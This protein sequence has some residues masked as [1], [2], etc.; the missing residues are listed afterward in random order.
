MSPSE[1][2]V[3]EN[4]DIPK[5]PDDELGK[6]WKVVED[7]VRSMAETTGV[8]VPRG[9][10]AVKN[11]TD[12]LAA[13]AQ[14][15]VDGSGRFQ[16]VQQTFDKTLTC[17]RTLGDIVIGPISQVFGGPA[18][19][20]FNALTFVILAYQG[21]KG[22]FE[23]LAQ[24]LQGFIESLGRL[25]DIKKL[26]PTPKL[27]LIACQQLMLFVNVCDLT[28]KLRQ[29]V[30]FKARAFF[31]ST[32][33]NNDEVKN[34]I[35]E[36]K[37]LNKKEFRQIQMDILERL[38]RVDRNVNGFMFDWKTG[39][40][41]KKWKSTVIDELGWPNGSVLQSTEGKIPI[42]FWKERLLKH[43][44]RSSHDDGRWLWN[45]ERFHNWA[46]GESHHMPVL[47]LEGDE[48]T[49]KTHLASKIIEHLNQLGKGSY[50]AYYFVEDS[51]KTE[52]N[53][54][55]DTEPV[56]IRSLLWQFA[57]SCRPFLKSTA[58]VCETKRLMVRYDDMW[59]LLISNVASGKTEARFFIVIDGL[60][61]AH[62]KFAKSLLDAVES[63]V[64]ACQ[65]IRILIT[66]VPAFFSDL[67]ETHEL[68]IEVIRL[69]DENRSDI[70]NFID[71]R[72]NRMPELTNRS[73]VRAARMRRRISNKLVGSARGD[74]RNMAH[75]LDKIKKKPLDQDWVENCL[76]GA[77]STAASKISGMVQSID[78]QSPH[79]IFDINEMIL[80]VIDGRTW[81][82]LRQMAAAL[83][84]AHAAESK[85]QQDNERN[86]TARKLK[87][88]I[89]GGTYSLFERDEDKEIKFKGGLS[90]EEA[91]QGIPHKRSNPGVA[92]GGITTDSMAIQLAEVNLV[93]HYLQTVCPKSLY[94][95]FG[96]TEFFEQK[97]SSEASYTCQ[98]PANAEL[99]LSLRCL[100]CLV[101]ER[102]PETRALYSYAA[103]NLHEHLCSAI[104][105]PG[106]THDERSSPDDE[107]GATDKSDSS[108]DEMHSPYRSQRD[109]FLQ[110]QVAGY[111]ARLFLE[112]YA[113]DSLFGFCYPV[114]DDRRSVLELKELP[115][116]W[117]AWI[118]DDKALNLLKTS[119]FRDTDVLR[120]T[121]ESGLVKSLTAPN[122]VIEKQPFELLK[123]AVKRA[124][125]HLL[126]PGA[127]TYEIET[128]FAF[129][130][131]AEAR[132]N[133]EDKVIDEDNI[134]TPTVE[135]VKAVEVWALR[136]SASDPTSVWTAHVAAVLLNL[137]KNGH[138][139]IPLRYVENL[140]REALNKDP[141][142]WKASYVLARAIERDEDAA[143]LLEGIIISYMSG[144]E[145]PGLSRDK[146]LLAE[147]YLEQGDRLW[148]MGGQENQVKAAE[149]YSKSV[150]K[151]GTHHTRY[152]SI[153]KRYAESKMWRHIA[154]L[155]K[156][157]VAGFPQRHGNAIGK[158]MWEGIYS[159]PFM[160]AL[161]R[162]ADALD[163]WDLLR[164]IYEQGEKGNSSFWVTFELRSSYGISLSRSPKHQDEALAVFEELMDRKIEPGFEYFERMMQN[165]VLR[166]IMPMYT[167][168]V[169]A[170]K[171]TK[172]EPPEF[173]ERVDRLHKD[174][175]KSYEKSDSMPLTVLYFSRY[176]LA[177]GK[178][179][180][181]KEVARDLVSQS[182]EM[183]L[184]D[185]SSD[186]Y[187]C[188]WQL[189]ALFW[190]FKDIDNAIAA[191]T[192][193]AAVEYTEHV[194][195]KEQW[196]E[197]MIEW[198]RRN[199][200]N[201][202]NS[203]GHG[204]NTTHSQD[205]SPDARAAPP[206]SVSG[207]ELAPEEHDDDG[208]ESGKPKEPIYGMKILC[209][210]CDKEFDN[211]NGMWTCIDEC[212]QV[213]FD[214][215][216]L[217][218]LQEGT[219]GNFVCSKDHL[220]EKFP[221][222]KFRVKELS[223]DEVRIK[224]NILS[225]KAWGKIIEQQYATKA[226]K[227]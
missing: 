60:A 189:Q 90:I 165:Q 77:S 35:E 138:K 225:L 130:L 52:S 178:S 169:A 2:A 179:Q 143:E 17:I 36:A 8:K 214:E 46:R 170:S 142:N 20:C 87:S 19:T 78:T 53:A 199:E 38:D 49:G 100:M 181:A 195:N 55:R 180:K 75:V 123:F 68:G 11:V 3:P 54:E 44:A 218:K 159:D 152:V 210:G 187:Q 171:M 174:F 117:S 41:E 5:D 190:T 155:M 45:H 101:D 144:E 112:D 163:E 204:A 177:R 201:K 134:W 175:M 84:L 102:K 193:L 33:L 186:D 69:R 221:E 167:A 108:D 200:S 63:Q 72:M 57:D 168:R 104:T 146:R 59:N 220:F 121:G 125:T 89:E 6:I 124:V 76:T 154:S 7:R 126:N 91:K 148:N 82:N 107:Y 62:T 50:V 166:Y 74:Y 157:L 164:A 127:T 28:L 191:V 14:R 227:V 26:N 56:I 202:N 129:L 224:G 42:F 176:Y 212:G 67:E 216:C 158:I 106:D 161:V 192:M 213:Q 4:P 43:L 80:W 1:V 149:A 151:D 188:F 115:A 12:L 71:D 10:L 25:D 105:E 147:L 32:F 140:A 85:S 128:S 58:A 79:N 211:P 9:D 145:C 209:D 206:P 109:P 24:L 21:Y 207:I 122:H 47:G 139:D 113:M 182:L 61:T 136:T 88:R 64:K 131:V 92:R 219:L 135:Q 81:L 97:L 103:E 137:N 183:M 205:D 184:N 194:R 197:Q 217:K 173:E 70:D 226:N 198:R 73:N 98:D 15:S 141:S 48:G 83:S 133:A 86:M 95:K 29:K 13:Q 40:D 116:S 114:S 65:R 66:G 215:E 160:I 37:K 18:N 110:A 223:K 99:V 120:H 118:M 111:L 162:T 156:Q 153:V 22:M 51:R 96:F 30:R 39:T 31:N 23:A 132:S 93:K 208:Q 196:E 185:D 119:L 94:D 172:T 34:L 150:E 27:R 222:Q 203:N 16:E